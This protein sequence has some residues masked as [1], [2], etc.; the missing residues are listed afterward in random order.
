MP[1]QKD[2]GWEFTDLSKFD[3]DAWSPQ[4]PTAT[5]T[6]RPRAR[7]SCRAERTG[8]L[9]VDGTSQRRGEAPDGVVVSTLGEAV[10]EHPELVEP[11]LGSLVRDRDKFAAQNTANWQGGLFVH[12]PAGTVVDEPLVATVIQATRRRACMA[13]ADRCRGRRRR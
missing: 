10:A 6:P 1:V 12:V 9:Q 7:R 11:H 2:K 3:P 4:A 5:S 13:L 8:V